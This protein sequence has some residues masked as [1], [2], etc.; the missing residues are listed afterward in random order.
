M[1]QGLGGNYGTKCSKIRAWDAV[2]QDSGEIIVLSVAKLESGML[3][4]KVPWK[5]WY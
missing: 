3:W 4:Y 5:L 2:V 1:V